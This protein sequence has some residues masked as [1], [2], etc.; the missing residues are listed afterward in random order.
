MPDGVQG[1]A[2]RRGL[3]QRVLAVGARAHC[4]VQRHA[5][6]A[7][8]ARASAQRAGEAADGAGGRLRVPEFRERVSPRRGGADHRAEHH[9]PGG[10]Q[11]W[12]EQEHGEGRPHEFHHD[13]R[14]ARR[15]GRQQGRKRRVV[16]EGRA[17][18]LRHVLGLPAGGDLR[19]KLRLLRRRRCVP[20]ALPG[21]AH[22]PNH[23]HG[24]RHH[25]DVLLAPCHDARDARLRLDQGELRA[26]VRHP[27]PD[28][29]RGLDKPR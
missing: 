10:R 2:A 13:R 14:W 28:L 25:V 20:G 21:Q 18:G 15:Q 6:A 5:G 24:R 19:R 22:A 26:A 27:H 12:L 11:E 17:G 7:P 3:R 9:V 23:G 16:S 8:A 1:V 4:A 29:G